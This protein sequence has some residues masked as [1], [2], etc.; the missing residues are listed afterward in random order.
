MLHTGRIRHKQIAIMDTAGLGFAHG[1]DCAIA[2]VPN[3]VDTYTEVIGTSMTD[4]ILSASGHYRIEIPLNVSLCLLTLT[5]S[6]GGGSGASVSQSPNIVRSGCGGGGSA[7]IVS[8][9][10]DVTNIRELFVIIADGGNGG[11]FGES[12]NNGSESI[13]QLVDFSGNVSQTIRA[14]GGHGAT[15]TEPGLPGIAHNVL[16]NGNLGLPGSAVIGSQGTPQGGSGGSTFLAM[17]G[18]G[19]LP[20]SALESSGS[21]GH[22]GGSGGGG[23]SPWGATGSGGRGGPGYVRVQWRNS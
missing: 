21:N 2:F 6:G 10:M 9:P 17:G 14:A 22:V 16:L 23:G 8:M 19:G 18:L 15:L 4:T 13:V 3:P 11:Q 1:C 5:G 20:S 12:G 7:S